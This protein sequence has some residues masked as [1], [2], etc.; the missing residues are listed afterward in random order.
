MGYPTLNKKK[1]KPAPNIIGILAGKG[2]VGKSTITTELALAL[3]KEGYKVGV[4]DADI[5]GPSIRHLLP[6]D[7]F[8]KT[9][10]E[11]VLPAD[12]KGV[13]VISSA[14]FRKERGFTG[15]RAPIANQIIAQFIEEVEW[16][17]L[18]FLLVDFPPGTGDVQITLMQRLF[19]NGAIIVTTPGKLSLLDVRQSMD[20]CLQMGVPLLGVLENM[21]YYLVPG[22]ETRHYLF[23]KEGGKALAEEFDVPL[24]GEI[25]ID[26]GL[27]QQDMEKTSTPLFEKLGK[28]VMDKINEEKRCKIKRVDRYHFSIEWLDGKK[29]LYQFSDVQGKCPC[30]EC[31]MKNETCAVDIEGIAIHSIGNYGVQFSFSKGCSKG[32]YPFSYLRRLDR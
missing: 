18:D 11:K 21:N 26:Q 30:I 17:S 14:Y 29:S 7:V 16:G 32:I 8:P 5:Y 2:G 15:V 9:V 25:P 31:I 10:G 19:F 3:N 22:S 1:L 12:S 13:A 20:M 4:L 23:G 27:N 6:E 24:I 28:T